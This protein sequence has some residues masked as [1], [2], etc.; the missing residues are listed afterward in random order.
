MPSVAPLGEV[1]SNWE[2]DS[3]PGSGDRQGIRIKPI[4]EFLGFSEQVNSIEAALRVMEGSGDGDATTVLDPFHIYRG[5]GDVESI[6]KLT[7]TR[8]PSRI[9]TTASTPT[10][11]G[12]HAP[13]R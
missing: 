6:A 1:D 7:P 13:D 3:M 4:M 10:P 2:V 11:A 12:A 5:G 9:S 8:L